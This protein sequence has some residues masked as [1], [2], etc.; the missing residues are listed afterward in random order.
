[1]FS[2]DAPKIRIEATSEALERF[3]PP[4][5]G[6]GLATGAGEATGGLLFVLFRD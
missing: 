1:M 2:P 3:F 6:S 4:R 5:E